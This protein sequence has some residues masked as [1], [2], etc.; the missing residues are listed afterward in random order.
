MIP[1]DVSQIAD[2]VRLFSERFDFVITSGGIGPTH[3]DMTFEGGSLQYDTRRLALFHLCAFRRW[4]PCSRDSL[5]FSL[6]RFSL[7]F[8]AYGTS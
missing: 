4:I 5:N 7:E 2:E 1:D 6:N 3:D 8:L